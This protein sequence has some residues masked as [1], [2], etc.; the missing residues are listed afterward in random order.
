MTQTSTQTTQKISAPEIILRD[1]FGVTVRQAREKLGWSQEMLADKAS[2]NRSYLGE[3]ERGIVMPSLA[4]IAK[5]AGALSTNMS[6]LIA[7]CE[8]ET[9]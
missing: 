5:L 2:L 4:T 3:V 8:E 6:V 9:S 7:R 1:R